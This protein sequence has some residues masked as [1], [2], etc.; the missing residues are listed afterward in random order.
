MAL[1]KEI[2]DQMDEEDRILYYSIKK[3]TPDEIIKGLYLGNRAHAMD[4]VT[5]KSFGVEYIIQI[6]S[7]KEAPFHGEEF[8]YKTVFFPD[9]EATD[10]SLYYKELIEFIND[11]IKKGNVF[12]HCD[13]GV[14]RSVTTV[15]SYLMVYK[16]MKYDDAFTLVRQKRPCMFPNQRFRDFLKELDKELN[17]KSKKSK[18][19]IW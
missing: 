10:I 15:I 16:K 1:V 19:I 9:I 8:K 14:S 3:K 13:A 4:K 12:V 7:K 2:V 5:L 6:T 11:K 18:C 17:R